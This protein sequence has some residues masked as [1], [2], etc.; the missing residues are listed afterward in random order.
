MGDCAWLM[1]DEEVDVDDVDDDCDGCCGNEEDV[2]IAD[3]EEKNDG[4]A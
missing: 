1:E 4:I 3:D 2:N